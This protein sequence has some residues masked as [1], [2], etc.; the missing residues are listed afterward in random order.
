MA[1][2]RRRLVPVLATAAVALVALSGVAAAGVSVSM[3]QSYPPPPGPADLPAPHPSGRTDPHRLRVMVAVGASGS[4]ASDVLVPYEVFARSGRFAV[5]LVAASREPVVLSGGVHVVPDHT[6]AETGGPSGRRA[7]VIVVPAVAQPTGEAEAPLRAWVA[8]QA[9]RGARVLGVCAGSQV[10]AASG[11]LDHRRATSHWSLIDSL[12]RA[13]PDTEWVPGRRHVE[14]GPVIT[15]AGVTSGAAGAL[16]TVERLA[17]TAE[18]ERVRAAL[19]YP[20]WRPAADTRIPVS[21]WAPADLPY[22]LNAAFPWL[23]PTIGLAVSDGIGESDLAAAAELYQGASFAA[24]TV[25][26]GPRST[27]TSRHGV[28]LLVKPAGPGAPRVDRLIAPGAGGPAD[29]DPALRRWAAGRSLPLGLP[30]R[31]DRQFAFD[32]MLRALA[33]DADVATAVATAKYVEYPLGQ[34]D[35]AGAR[36]P[37]R[38]TALF[39]GAVGASTL[40]GWGTVS[41]AGGKARR[42][43]EIRHGR[44]V[45]IAVGSMAPSTAAAAGRAGR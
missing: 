7:D 34:L 40:V 11:V 29:V 18:A 32:P 42:R 24:R 15:T 1:G 2:R 20:A 4:V 28:T 23:R 6:F 17:G 16:Q 12:R 19:G 30:G 25:V 8:A 21:R 38:P 22:G 43:G 14:D 10:L 36:W 44:P 5:S 26:I 33:R 39:A 9:S 35:L 31:S 3:A 27:V 13:H 45:R 41:V 37:W